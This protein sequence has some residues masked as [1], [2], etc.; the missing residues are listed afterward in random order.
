MAMISNPNSIAASQNGKIFL[1]TSTN[2]IERI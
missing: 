2:T 1:P